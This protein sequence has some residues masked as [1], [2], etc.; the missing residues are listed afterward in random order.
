LSFLAGGAGTGFAETRTT[1]TVPV[2]QSNVELAWNFNP[3]S[4]HPGE[5]TLSTLA[6]GGAGNLGS[7]SISSSIAPSTK[8]SATINC[9]ATCA[10]STNLPAALLDAGTGQII[11]TFTSA[12]TGRNFTVSTTVP[13]TAWPV[14]ATLTSTSD[15]QVN[16]DTLVPVTSSVTFPTGMPSRLRTGKVVLSARPSASCAQSA[17]APT[18]YCTQRRFEVTVDIATLTG[19]VTRSIAGRTATI[20]AQ[21]AGNTLVIDSQLFVG[22]TDFDLAATYVPTDSAV[23]SSASAG[24]ARKGTG[25][26]AITVQVASALISGGLFAPPQMPEKQRPEQRLRSWTQWN[27]RDPRVGEA[28]FVKVQFDPELATPT[29]YQTN[30]TLALSEPGNDPIPVDGMLRDHMI[31]RRAVDRGSWS[32]ASW[33]SIMKKNPD[34]YTQNRNLPSCTGC[35]VW[36]VRDLDNEGDRAASGGLTIG[37]RT[38]G[39]MSYVDGVRTGITGFHLSVEPVAGTEKSTASIDGS[40]LT[41]IT[42][43]RWNNLIAETPTEEASIKVTVRLNGADLDS[44]TDLAECF[45]AGFCLDTDVTGAKYVNPQVMP[46]GGQL[47][48]TIPLTDAQVAKIRAGATITVLTEAPWGMVIESPPLAVRSKSIASQGTAQ[49]SVSG[50][51]LGARA[52]TPDISS[53]WGLLGWGFYEST[54]VFFE[55]AFGKGGVADFFIS[56][57][58]ILTQMVVEFLFQGGP[59][60]PLSALS[61]VIKA[62]TSASKAALM[63][64]KIAQKVI[65]KGGT[66]VTTTQSTVARWARTLVS[67]FVTV[68]A[69]VNAKPGRLAILLKKVQ[70]VVQEHITTAMWHSCKA[71]SVIR[72]ATVPVPLQSDDPLF[73]SSNCVRL[74]YEAATLDVSDDPSVIALDA[75]QQAMA[76]RVA[77]LQKDNPP[78]VTDVGYGKGVAMQFTH[79]FSAIVR[80]SVPGYDS[81]SDADKA[82]GSVT[83]DAYDSLAPSGNLLGNLAQCSFAGVCTAVDGLSASPGANAIVLAGVFPHK[84]SWTPAGALLRVTVRMPDGSTTYSGLGGIP[85][86][87]ERYNCWSAWEKAGKPPMADMVCKD[88]DAAERFYTVWRSSGI[89]AWPAEF[90]AEFDYPRDTPLLSGP[91]P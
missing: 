37:D 33:D 89:R 72:D 18:D 59:F 32:L 40:L 5:Q 73:K 74:A 35:L 85:F 3:A 2:E 27:E 26:A 68:G 52:E 84:Y 25:G 46:L 45:Y 67:K 70:G 39:V 83:I 91:L 63:G 20:A 60:G 48:L 66:V 13:R 29:D 10:A 53:P 69:D 31:Q 56:L 11:G 28:V 82:K 90:K 15:S 61:G 36:D 4:T 87:G 9:A 14:V 42:A 81:M 54:K 16:R 6:I 49:V 22:G 38:L 19:S 8:T 30:F 41:V 1:L 77:R 75:Y 12:A 65:T 57:T 24:L 58:G 55:S 76:S 78:P 71:T 7:V 79:S 43:A 47:G 86:A 17:W 21:W 51:W 62:V 44:S 64:T 88:Q 80:L 23:S 34:A 50:T